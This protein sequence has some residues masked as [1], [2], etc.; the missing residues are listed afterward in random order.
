MGDME[1]FY[2]YNIFVEKK[3]NIAKN[4]GHA[5]VEKMKE[6]LDIIKDSDILIALKPPVRYSSY[7]TLRDKQHDLHGSVSPAYHAPLYYSK[8]ITF[9]RY[10][11]RSGNRYRLAERTDNKQ[12]AQHFIRNRKDI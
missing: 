6:V 1:H 3:T 11:N 8:P 4:M 7:N 9:K 12:R 5:K 10:N 2:I